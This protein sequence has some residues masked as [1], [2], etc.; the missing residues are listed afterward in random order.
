MAVTQPA[1]GGL[2]AGLPFY[3]RYTF[4]LHLRAEILNNL[5]AGVVGLMGAVARKGLGASDLE[6]TILTT[7]GSA[8]NLTAILWSH[9]MEG[10]S[11]RPF[12][13]A[14]AFFGRVS[15]VLMAFATTPAVFI[16]ICCAY[17][18]SET[19]F[20]PAQN[21]LLQANYS[22]TIRGR[23]FGTITAVSKPAF[24]AAAWAAGHALDLHADAY[25]WLFPAAGLVGTLS[26][27][28][29]ARIRVRRWHAPAREASTGPLAAVRGFTRIMRR[30]REFD[31][32]ER[33]F[34]LYGMAFMIVLPVNIFLLVDELGMS[35]GTISLCTL[36]VFQVVNAVASRLGGT[37][38]DRLG[39]PRLASLS[40]A[41]LVFYSSLLGASALTLSVPLAFA[42]FVVFGV[43]MGGVNNAW[44]LGAM[45]FAGDRDA[46]AYMG[47]HVACVGVRGLFG[48]L[49]GH[50]L[51]LAVEH[52][53][54]GLSGW[55]IPVVYAVSAALF[56]V[57]AFAMS[58]QARRL[59]LSAA[60]KAAQGEGGE[61][62]GQR[63]GG[64]EGIVKGPGEDGG[65][66]GDH[67]DDA[68]ADESRKKVLGLAGHS[69]EPGGENRGR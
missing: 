69:P 37:L 17:F 45:K 67:R 66:E 41:I 9:L 4:R 18:L 68:G 5:F 62:K 49:I 12:I 43:A 26:Y 22:A 40:F 60:E 8:A 47:A 35:Y 65:R 55:G 39:A 13:L 32:F 2:L 24:L 54:T 29:Y 53:R 10:R 6:V 3:S 14:A 30:D 28:Q 63:G 57:G 19:I 56:A 46:A 15:L 58:R 31:R 21:A 27:L 61:E 25:I 51:M 1:P 59:D 20:V 64:G 34:M 33:N 52:P 38:L 48:P 44:S 16:P 7:A 36:V 42:A 23:A 11:K 50:A